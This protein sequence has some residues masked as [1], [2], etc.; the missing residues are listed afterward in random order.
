MAP[1]TMGQSDSSQ[2][3]VC[4][5]WW[6]LKRETA[7]WTSSRQG[8]DVGHV[9]V[10]RMAGHLPGVTGTVEGHRD[11]GWQ[12]LSAVMAIRL[13][14]LLFVADSLLQLLLENLKSTGKH[15]LALCFL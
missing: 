1:A 15:L 13:L 7:A 9:R 5:A 2:G 14:L 10:S 8:A 3:E 6:G 11:K 4:A 12:A